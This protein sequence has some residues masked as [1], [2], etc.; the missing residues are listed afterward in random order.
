LERYHYLVNQKFL[1]GLPE[2]EA[3]EMDRLGRQIDDSFAWFYEPILERV[4]E[5]LRQRGRSD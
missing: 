3:E 2:A 4:C 5:L 1:R